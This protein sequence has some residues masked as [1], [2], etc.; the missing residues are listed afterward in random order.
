MFTHR[1]PLA[2]RGSVRHWL[3]KQQQQ[4]HHH[5]QQNH[6]QQL[7]LLVNHPQHK[8]LCALARRHVAC[9]VIVQR[10][11]HCCTVA[12]AALQPSPAQ[13]QP[14]QVTRRWCSSSS[15]SASATTTTTSSSID[16]GDGSSTPLLL[17]GSLWPDLVLRDEH[18]ASGSLGDMEDPEDLAPAAAL[19]KDAIAACL[20]DAVPQKPRH[21]HQRVALARQLLEQ[22]LT[23][24]TAVGFTATDADDSLGS[25]ELG[26]LDSA[27]SSML[28]TV[29]E[30]YTH[31]AATGRTSAATAAT[32]L[33]LQLTHDGSGAAD[34]ELRTA[35]QA[36]LRDAGDSNSSATTATL[37]HQLPP[38]HRRV[39][40]TDNMCVAM[41]EAWAQLAGNEV[42]H[43][44]PTAL[45]MWRSLEGHAPHD[46]PWST[47]A[48]RDA[49]LRA[50][51]LTAATGWDV[52]G[53][54]RAAAMDM[55]REWLDDGGAS[56]TNAV[57]PSCATYALGLQTLS[58][59]RG[60]GVLRD[61]IWLVRSFAR[62]PHLKDAD[63]QVMA[64]ALRVC[65]VYSDL[66]L[67]QHAMFPLLATRS[68]ALTGDITSTLGGTLGGLAAE[69]LLRDAQSAA[70]EATI[71]SC[72]Y[73]EGVALCPV[74][75][76]TGSPPSPPHTQ[77]TSG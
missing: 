9:T 22:F 4:Q 70:D 32:Q 33:L 67:F 31:V 56:A 27:L 38:A 8:Q 52:A 7:L 3:R 61:A 71:E 68:P 75:S 16:D 63:N 39:V 42:S 76:P 53:A 64:M 10:H 23:Q 34:S 48:L 17:A 14:L 54:G 36:V 5:Q 30:G 40:L 72:R 44:L 6:Q 2:V 35:L 69:V 58:H 73:E 55:L 29:L 62:Q 74:S 49:T 47:T 25:E 13:A 26:R 57:L 59:S 15:S 66:D 65:E 77:A 18:I 43:A 24:A 51:A 50:C 46:R 41:L 37:Q 20:S 19:F 1:S 28:Q 60:P 45:A 12:V 11:L 21:L